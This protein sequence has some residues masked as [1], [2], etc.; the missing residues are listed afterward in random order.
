MK[1]RVAPAD[2][3]SSDDMSGNGGNGGGGGGGADK[4]YELPT[5]EQLARAARRRQRRKLRS[6]KA[7]WNKLHALMWVG[8]SC[9][10]IVVTDFLSI[11]LASPAAQRTWVAVGGALFAL[12]SLSVL[13]MACLL[14]RIEPNFETDDIART[15][16]RLVPLTS[17]ASLACFV[18]L[19][20]G[21]W[22]VYKLFTP[23]VLLWLWFGLVMSLHFIPVL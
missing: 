14:P 13:Y 17:A 3:D 22:P 23:L 5:D 20:V 2:A 19:C 7:D 21:L 4:R 1:R 8:T 12:V 16:P 6:D 10:L 18:C 9:V 11:V 15:H